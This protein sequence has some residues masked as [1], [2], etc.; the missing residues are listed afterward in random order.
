MN[1]KN[2]RLIEIIGII[3][4]IIGIFIFVTGWQSIRDVW[5]SVTGSTQQPTV[6]VVQR[7]TAT[8][9]ASQII[10]PRPTVIFNTPTP[11]KNWLS[12]QFPL[13]E[14]VD[15]VVDETANG[16]IYAAIKDSGVYKTID[17]GVTWRPIN[18]GLGDISVTNIALSKIDSAILY[19]QTFRGGFW[20]TDNGGQ[21]WFFVSDGC[22]NYYDD[23][24]VDPGNSNVLYGLPY[25]TNLLGD[26]V[27]YKSVD[28]TASWD[29]INRNPIDEYGIRGLKYKFC[30]ADENLLFLLLGNNLGGGEGIFLSSDEGQSWRKLN[31]IGLNY[32]ILDFNFSGNNC[33]EIFAGTTM[34]VWKSEDQGASWEPVNSTLPR[35]GN[36]TIVSRI[37]VERGGSIFIAVNEFGVFATDDKGNTWENISQEL[38]V[39]EDDDIQSLDI[40]S[41]GS[42]LFL[43]VKRQGL[44][45]IETKKLP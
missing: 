40:S 20:K 23:L 37:V 28:G 45:R 12:L 31:T 5:V 2:N 29:T 39:N 9:N 17:H 21:S 10:T 8:S 11:A 7:N 1:N 32:E 34:G 18:N 36:N 3:S 44:F 24:A 14:L 15:F 4:S 16:T 30:P 27:L 6:V 13:G 19:V 33:D 26:L 25:C 41:D 43:N 38:V 22:G 42:F 35:Q